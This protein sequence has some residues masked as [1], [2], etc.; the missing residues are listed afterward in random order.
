MIWIHSNSP[1]AC[2]KARASLAN[3][4]DT[5]RLSLADLQ[6]KIETL[7]LEEADGT[8]SAAMINQAP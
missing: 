8:L 4:E 7:V 6:D 5:L 1:K 3:V 2:E